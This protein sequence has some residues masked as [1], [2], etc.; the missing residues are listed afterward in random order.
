M[1]STPTTSISSKPGNDSGEENNDIEINTTTTVVNTTTQVVVVGPSA[2]APTSPVTTKS[3]TSSSSSNS[4]SNSTSTSNSTSKSP[5]PLTVTVNGN[6]RSKDLKEHDVVCEKGRGDHERWPGNKLYRHLINVNKETYNDLAPIERSNIIGSIIG[7]IQEK[8]GWFVSHS[9]S[10]G[11]WAK[12]TEEKVRKKVSD[13][14]RREVRRRREKRSHNSLF[15]AK[16]RAIKELEEVE[17]AARDILERVDDPRQT[18]VLFGPGARRHPGNKTYW[19]HMKINLDQYIISPYGAR[20]VISRN[21]VQIIRNQHGRF[22]EQDPKTGL[23]YSI[24]DKRALEKTSHALSNMKYK[25]RKRHPDEPPELHP[26]DIMMYQQQHGVVGHALPPQQQHGQH[27]GQQQHPGVH[28]GGHPHHLAY[29]VGQHPYGGEQQQMVYGNNG[30]AH[31]HGMMDECEEKILEGDSPNTIFAKKRTKKFRLLNRMDDYVDQTPLKGKGGGSSNNIIN[32]NTDLTN[33]PVP[34]MMKEGKIISP[35]SGSSNSIE[36]QEQR[37]PN[38]YRRV[39]HVAATGMPP[40]DGNYGEA[41]RGGVGADI[42]PRISHFDYM[43]HYAPPPAAGPGA[44]FKTLAYAAG[45]EYGAQV[46]APPHGQYPPPP[47][48]RRYLANPNLAQQEQQHGGISAPPQ[49][50]GGHQQPPSAVNNAQQHEAAL[51]ARR[52]V[53]KATGPA[54]YWVSNEW[55]QQ[56]PPPEAYYQA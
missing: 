52:R 18:D 4:S 9:D 40:A 31:A 39:Q 51:M 28:G 34:G 46:Q 19:H 15:S 56:Q 8:E 49:G 12:L 16:L 41:Y 21:I 3:K 37:D 17:A 26:H 38:N 36:N 32:N 29:R 50:G 47:H 22:L 54:G 27:P 48:M 33:T 30:N 5:K 6:D 45:A 2:T 20:S 14:L 11:N 35:N 55:A 24:S 53:L 1:M 23:W 44:A 25:T 13:D 43:K 7:A 10:T 42:A